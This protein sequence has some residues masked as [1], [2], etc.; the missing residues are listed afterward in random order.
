MQGQ[1]SRNGDVGDFKN[2]VPTWDGKPETFSHFVTE[3]RWALNSTKKDERALLASRIVRRALQSEHPTLVALL[4]KLDPEE[5]NSEDGVEKLVKF[6]EASP[7][8]RQPLPDAGNKIGGYYR[9]LH[10][11]PQEAIRAFL[12]R[13]DRVQNEMLRVLQRL[14]REREL[15]FDDYEVDVDELKAFCGIPKGKSFYFGP[16]EGTDAEEDNQEEAEEEESGVRTPTPESSQGRPFSRSSR[17]RRS[18]SRGSRSSADQSAKGDDK[19]KPKGKDLLQR[20]MEKGLMPLATL[21]VIR[22]WMILEMSTSTIKAATRNKLG[23]H[24]IKQAL[25][26]MYEDR[27]SKGSRPFNFGH[28]GWTQK[29]GTMTTAPS[30]TRT[31][32]GLGGLRTSGLCVEVRTVN[33]SPRMRMKRATVSQTPLWRTFKKSSRR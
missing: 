7:M 5:F 27:G 16:V 30:T 33:G 12:V 15:T 2:L 31:S 19:K 26:S 3:I 21:D 4:Y 25:L 18:S 6:L 22:G 23:Y 20:R 10:K 29:H 28:G 11:K 17:D 1:G 24:E 32:M 14:L 8:N 9:R 13:E